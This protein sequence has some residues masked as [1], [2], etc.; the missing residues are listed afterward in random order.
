LVDE[1]GGAWLAWQRQTT[2]PGKSIVL[3][4]KKADHSAATGDAA[5]AMW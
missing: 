3:T 2:Q 1:A 5:H 4:G